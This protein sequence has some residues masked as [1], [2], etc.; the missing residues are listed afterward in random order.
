MGNIKTLDNFISFEI[1][2]LKP[3]R[4]PDICPAC[5]HEIKVIKIGAQYY[6]RAQLPLLQKVRYAKDYVVRGCSRCG[7]VFYYD[8]GNK[9][10]I[11][12][13]FKFE[14]FEFQQ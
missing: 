13:S 8:N 3:G 1:G 2:A 4:T 11:E 7:R 12:L 6:N 5:A 14:D 10:L 9:R